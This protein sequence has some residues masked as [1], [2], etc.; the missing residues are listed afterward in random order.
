MVDFLNLHPN[1]NPITR[2]RH[3]TAET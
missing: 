2:T 3:L 1:L